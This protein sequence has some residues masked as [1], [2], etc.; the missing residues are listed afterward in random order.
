MWFVNLN[1]VR[2]CSKMNDF[3]NQIVRRSTLARTVSRKI[4]YSRAKY[5]STVHYTENHMQKLPG[6]DCLKPGSSAAHGSHME[7]ENHSELCASHSSHQWY[8]WTLIKLTTVATGCLQWLGRV[9]NHGPLVRH[10]I[11]F[12]GL[13]D[14]LTYSNP[15]STAMCHCDCV[16]QEQNPWM[17]TQLL[18]S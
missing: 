5:K 7:C 2:Q 13:S 14:K 11:Q 3:V 17:I 4:R 6:P 8:Y 18:H 15:I 9:T 10:K 12:V 16:R 1:L